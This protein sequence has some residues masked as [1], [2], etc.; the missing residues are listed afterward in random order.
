[1]LFSIYIYCII[2]VKTQN[3]YFCDISYMYVVFIIVLVYFSTAADHNSEGF[4][5][6]YFLSKPDR[7]RLFGTLVDQ[8]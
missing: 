8:P 6:Y 4:Y 1:M 2:I 5:I 3:I 7:G